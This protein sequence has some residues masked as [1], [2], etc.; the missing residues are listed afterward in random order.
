MAEYNATLKVPACWRTLINVEFPASLAGITSEKHCTGVADPL[1]HYDDQRN[2]DHV[3]EN[4]AHFRL[5]LASGQGNYY[6]GVDLYAPT[7]EETE[8]VEAFCSNY[9]IRLAGDSYY[10]NIQWVG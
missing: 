5:T 1:P 8:I 7:A 6:G 9:R 3:F 10:V 4:G 2:V